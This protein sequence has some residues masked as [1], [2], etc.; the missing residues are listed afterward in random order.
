MEFLEKIFREPEAV[1]LLLELDE[2]EFLLLLFVVGV[3]EQDPPVD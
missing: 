3:L 1:V 2:A